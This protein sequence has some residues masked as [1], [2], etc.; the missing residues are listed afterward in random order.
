MKTPCKIKDFAVVNATT[1]YYEKQGAGS[2]VV[3]IAG[4]TGDAG[5]FTRAADL[6]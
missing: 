6:L 3:L 5:N 2:A 1:L 4:S